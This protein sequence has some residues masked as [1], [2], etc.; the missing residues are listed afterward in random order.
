MTYHLASDARHEIGRELSTVNFIGRL[1]ESHA[2]G[3]ADSTLQVI[4]SQLDGKY[5][6]V[7][8]NGEPNGQT[9]AI[10]KIDDRH[11]TSITKDQG[12]V[13]GTSKSEISADGNVLRI[14]NDY[15][16]T[17][18]NPTAKTITEYWDRK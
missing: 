7:M 17:S 18:T 11:L 14:D 12:R 9:T 10:R 4:Q 2:P 8:I 1:Y 6:P 15:A 3:Q 16:I 5:V 13:I